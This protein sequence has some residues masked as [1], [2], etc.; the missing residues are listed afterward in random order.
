MIRYVVVW[1]V[2]TGDG[3]SVEATGAEDVIEAMRLAE[4]QNGIF[5]DVGSVEEV[6]RKIKEVAEV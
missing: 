4:E 6:I 2:A 5:F 3:I 1:E